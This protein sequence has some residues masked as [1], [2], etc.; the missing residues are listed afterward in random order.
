MSRIAVV[1]DTNSGITREEAKKLGVFLL[2][3]PFIVDG[4]EYFEGVTCTYEQFFDMLA[5]GS[6]VS[7]SQPAPEDLTAL[8]DTILQNYDSIVH[9]PMSSALSGSCGTAKALA[10]DYNGRVCVVDNKRISLSQRESVLDALTLIKKGL[11][12]AEICVQLEETAYNSSIYLA[13]N[14]LELLK[15]SGRVTAA[16]A[17]LATLLGLKPVLQIQGEKL[18]AYAKVRGMAAAEKTM[19][20][21]I[22]K[23]MQTRFAGKPVHIAV[24]YSGDIRPALE[25]RKTVRSYFGD[26]HIELYKLPI[27]ICCHV[28]AGVKAIA[29]YEY[30]E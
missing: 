30:F 8:W 28:G 20:K 22:E 10:A 24:A 6:D 13:V 16:G 25:W 26:S 11:T 18:D 23:D 19:L 27:S 4:K 5:A 14:T 2:S 7:T 9:I 15:K 29:C 12:A 21:A 1:T 3:M 17:A